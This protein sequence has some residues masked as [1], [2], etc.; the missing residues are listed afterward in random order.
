MPANAGKE[1]KMDR[2]N[3]D[4]Y[5]FMEDEKFQAFL[6]SKLKGKRVPFNQFMT[7]LNRCKKKY[8]FYLNHKYFYRDIPLY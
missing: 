6:E 7:I 1:I 5:D 2:Y 4:D 8:I 3:Q